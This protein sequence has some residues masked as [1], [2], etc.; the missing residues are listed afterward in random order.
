MKRRALS[1][2]IALALCLNL[3][4]V[5][6]LAA[7][8]EAGGGPCPHHL[9]HTD[10]CGYVPPV[11]EQACT[12]SHGDDCYTTETNCVHEHTAECYPASESDPEGAEPALCAH[13]CTEES[14]CV[15]RTLSCRHSHDDTCGYVP[16]EPGA[17]CTY[18]CRICPIEE[19]IGEL[20][21]S[22]SP[23]SSGQVQACLD[24]IFAL[25][26]ELTPDEQQQLDLSPCAALLEQI[27]GM[28][29]E[30]LSTDPV[31]KYILGSDETIG[32]AQ[33]VDTPYIIDTREYTLTG[34]GASAVQ[35]A[36]GGELELQGT[37][38][39]T[40]GIGVQVE[41]GGSLR[42]TGTTYIEGSSYALDG[43]PARMYASPP[44]STS[45][46][47]PRFGR[48]AILPPCCPRTAPF[49]TRA[50]ARFCCRT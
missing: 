7:G 32:T 21:P 45:A 37:V 43:S 39:A 44:A 15:T 25:Y 4:P 34:L 8:G 16:G 1:F 19:L 33:V 46:K 20:P 18:V 29:A 48:P 50:A 41:S 5:W 2:I 42:I 27:D 17:P 36:A 24:E 47:R 9:T 23:S 40:K 22:V 35:V 38:V 49:L 13:V 30:V 11:P 14:G 12:H 3:C 31:Q 10:T 26:D 28:A 6:G